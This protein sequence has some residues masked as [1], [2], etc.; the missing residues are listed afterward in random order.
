MWRHRRGRVRKTRSS[1]ACEE[2]VKLF[3]EFACEV[4]FMYREKPFRFVSRSTKEWSSQ[5]HRVASMSRTLGYKDTRT[6]LLFCHL[7]DN[8]H[9]KECTPLS[10]TSRRSLF[11]FIV[12]TVRHMRTPVAHKWRAY[13]IILITTCLLER[14]FR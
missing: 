6:C 11:P 13:C 12:L 2:L 1:S 5:C 7:S 3:Q 9:T 10:H 14:R 4:S 8:V